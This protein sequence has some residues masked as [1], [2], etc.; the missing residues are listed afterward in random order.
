MKIIALLLTFSVAHTANA[1]W[2]SD[3]CARHLVSDDPYQ[4]ESAGTEDLLKAYKQTAVEVVVYQNIEKERKR[5]SRRLAM[6]G[7]ELRSRPLSPYA[8]F[9]TRAYSHLESYWH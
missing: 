9:V 8:Q 3:F 5:A 4:Y 7:D 1:G 2:W 6:I